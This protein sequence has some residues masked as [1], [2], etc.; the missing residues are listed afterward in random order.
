MFCYKKVLFL[1]GTF[2]FLIKQY[3]LYI[4]GIKTRR[5]YSFQ[6]RKNKRTFT[7][8]WARIPKNGK[9]KEGRN[10]FLRIRPFIFLFLDIP[11]KCSKL[12]ETLIHF[13]ACKQLS[14]KCCS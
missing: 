9:Y 4:N 12:H 6:L 5:T 11:Y 8:Y 13:L 3:V 10:S 14:N 1:N 2:A 7:F